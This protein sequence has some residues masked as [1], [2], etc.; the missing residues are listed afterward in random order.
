MLRKK[1]G[2]SE[3]FEM[4]Q[5]SSA[6]LV[7]LQRQYRIMEGDREAYSEEVNI[8]KGFTKWFYFI[9]FF[10]FFSCSR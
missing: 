10:S 8:F 4:E 7:R 1:N 6:E 9:L 3:D 5:M 2:N